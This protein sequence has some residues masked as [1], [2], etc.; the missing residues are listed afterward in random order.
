LAKL[1]FGKKPLAKLVAAK[2]ARKGL[3]KGVFDKL[4]KSGIKA[5]P[6]SALFTG[7]GKP[8]AL[9]QM[10]AQ[11]NKAPPVVDAVQAAP[12]VPFPGQAAPVAAPLT[13]LADPEAAALAEAE[14]KRK[15]YAAQA[16][17]ILG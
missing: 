10:I 16:K 14:R 3:Q 5:S 9:A 6:L 8:L 11:Q 17:T 12:S 2:L 4:L 7:K 1:K 13:E 15:L